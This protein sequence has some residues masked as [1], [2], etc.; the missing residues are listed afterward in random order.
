MLSFLPLFFVSLRNSETIQ[1]VW[2]NLLCVRSA[3]KI[4]ASLGNCTKTLDLGERLQVSP[5]SLRSAS[6]HAKSGQPEGWDYA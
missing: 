6:I 1:N 4:A 5:A 2:L 3:P